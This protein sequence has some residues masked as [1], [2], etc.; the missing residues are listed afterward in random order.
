MAKKP[1][2]KLYGKTY[3][4]R[5]PKMKVWR[6]YLAFFDEDKKDMP[7]EEYLDR[8]VEL[9]VLAFGQKAVTKEAIDDN[10]ELSD[11]VPLVRE[12]FLWL[13]SLTFAKLVKVPN[14][15]AEPVKPS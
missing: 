4:P 15:E 3:T 8:N 5:P 6:E 13:Q 12:L 1:E 11:I 10:V 9:I 7:L 14:G 2:I